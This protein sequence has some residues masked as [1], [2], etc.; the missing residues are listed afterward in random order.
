MGGSG[1]E[2]PV[3]RPVVDLTGEGCDGREKAAAIEG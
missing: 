3:R 1:R 2:E